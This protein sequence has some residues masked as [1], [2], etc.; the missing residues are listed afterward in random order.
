MTNNISISSKKDKKGNT[1]YNGPV[2]IEGSRY[3]AS[4]WTDKKNAERKRGNITVKE[5]EEYVEKA[6]VMYMPSQYKDGEYYCVVTMVDNYYMYVSNLT[7]GKDADGNPALV[8]E[9]TLKGVNL[10]EK[11]YQDSLASKETPPV[12]KK[13]VPLGD[14]VADKVADKIADEKPFDDALPEF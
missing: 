13:E 8:G 9:L 3:Y 1:Y 2:E 12:A 4:L 6:K 10:K 5:G 11:A 14:R 7:I